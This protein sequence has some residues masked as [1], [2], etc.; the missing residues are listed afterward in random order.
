MVE[1]IA[2]Y[3]L[4]VG[5]VAA[6]QDISDN[7]IINGVVTAIDED[8]NTITMGG[9]L[10]TYNVET[11]HWLMAD[12]QAFIISFGETIAEAMQGFDDSPLPPAGG[13]ADVE[14]LGEPEKKE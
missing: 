5:M 1:S 10:Y 11:N 7:E 4:V 2:D 9:D 13:Y 6:L 8:N 3:G 14:P 12:G